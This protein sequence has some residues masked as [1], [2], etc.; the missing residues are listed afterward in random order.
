MRELLAAGA[1]ANQTNE[2]GWSGLIYAATYNHPE[3]IRELLAAGADVCAEC[4]FND[5]G[6]TALQIAQAKE[7]KR[8]VELLLASAT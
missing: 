8:C 4:Q 5:Y 2:Y 1:N 7:H 3:C 6:K